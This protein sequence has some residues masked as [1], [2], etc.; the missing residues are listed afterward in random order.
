MSTGRV[1]APALVTLSL[2][3][4]CGEQGEPS[5]SSSKPQIPVVTP[6]KTVLYFL[7]NPQDHDTTMK[8]CKNDPGTLGRTPEC[9]N[10]AEAQ[11]KIFTWGRE[12]ALKRMRGDQP[13]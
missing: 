5:G 1:F 9:I 3:A 7:E 10:A 11:K 4:G 13:S 8:A 12:E 2:L 6:T